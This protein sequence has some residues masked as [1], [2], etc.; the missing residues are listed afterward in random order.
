MGKNKFHE[1]H[2]VKDGI[3]CKIILIIKLAVL[4]CFQRSFI[5]VL[6]LKTHVECFRNSVS[7]RIKNESLSICCKEKCN[8]NG[9]TTRN[10]YWSRVSNSTC[11][12]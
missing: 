8:V 5:F 4:E 3:N 2:W 10:A 12:Q 11:T 7:R 1:Y 9:G 6:N